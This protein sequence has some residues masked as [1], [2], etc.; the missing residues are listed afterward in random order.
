MLYVYNQL[1]LKS[2]SQ[3]INQHTYVYIYIYYMWAEDMTCITICITIYQIIFLSF[4]KSTIIPMYASLW[5]NQ[6]NIIHIY[7]NKQTSINLKISCILNIWSLKITTI[8]PT[9]NKS[10]Q[11]SIPVRISCRSLSMVWQ[12]GRLGFPTTFRGG[13][14]G[15]DSWDFGGIFV[16][17]SCGIHGIIMEFQ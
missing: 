12:A 10:R 16:W 4:H 17:F 3:T 9:Y 6:N 1:Y 2:N 13:F 11:R 7:I 15:F 8:F 5:T 14:H